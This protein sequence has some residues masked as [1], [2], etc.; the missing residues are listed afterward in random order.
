MRAIHVHPIPNRSHVTDGSDCWCDPEVLQ[1]C[2]DCDLPEP[3]KD[4][5]K[6]HGRGLVM[7]FD[8][9]LPCVIVHRAR[10]DEL[11]PDGWE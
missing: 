1:A 8:D 7:V 2:D 11:L 4:C 5:W 9:E 10:V 6:C 3:Q